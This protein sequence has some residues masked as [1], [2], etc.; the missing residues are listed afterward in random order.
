[1]N[2]KKTLSL[3]TAL[4]LCL[5]LAGCGSAAGTPAENKT[6]S[7][8]TAQAE[9]GEASNDAARTVNSN[10]SV[11]IT[12]VKDSS[13]S[14]AAVQTEEELLAA[15]AEAEEDVE[16]TVTLTLSDG[17]SFSD[18]TGV[19]ISGDTVT[20]SAGG[21]YRVT[22]TLTNGQIIINAPE[23]KVVLALDGVSVICENSAALYVLDAKKVILS[24]L[25][26]RKHVF[27]DR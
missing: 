8:D 16:T 9:S 3:L 7:A 12:Q 6:A 13:T 5:S 2:M 1:M 21:S 23:E 15:E 11:N 24:R 22:G 19:T 20:I 26:E 18:G 27:L 17:A 14:T 25:R 4:A 10:T